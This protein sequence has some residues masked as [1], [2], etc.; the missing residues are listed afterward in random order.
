[1]SHRLRG[2]LVAVVVA[3]SMRATQ[4]ADAADPIVAPAPALWGGLVPG[5]YG[6]GYARLESTEGVVHAW[7]PATGTAPPMRFGDYLDGDAERFAA[8][9]AGAHVEK[10][11]IDG[12]LASPLFGVRSAPPVGRTFPLI[13]VAQ[14]NGEDVAD[15]VV[16]CE[17]L[18][19]TPDPQ[20]VVGALAE[21]QRGDMVRAI[22]MAGAML[23]ADTNRIGVVGHSFGARSALLLA[24]RDPRIRAIVSLDGGIGTATARDAFERAATRARP[25][26]RAASRA[27]HE[28][29]VR[30]GGVPGARRA[31]AGYAGHGWRGSGG[32]GAH[33]KLPARPPPL[34]RPGGAVL[35]DQVRDAS[36]IPWIDV[37]STRWNSAA[38]CFALNPSESAREK[39]AITPWLRARRA[40]ASARL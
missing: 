20:D 40:F 30:V 3:L 33:R 18:A 16:M 4:V 21:A 15:Q 11:T 31:D 32:G 10:G 35:R 2:A 7:Y 5:A 39:L 29:R 8:Q 6:V 22:G 9:L 24:M 19:T 23:R 13:V 26:Q 17:Y 34:S 27:L 1:M 38:D 12:L 28:L 25:H 36:K 37:S 14:G